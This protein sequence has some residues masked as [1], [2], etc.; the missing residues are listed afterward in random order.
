MILETILKIIPVVVFLLPGYLLIRIRRFIKEYLDEDNF[1]LTIQS[2]FF[3]FLVFANFFVLL[4][5]SIG[6]IKT[7]QIF[8]D[9]IASTETNIG[10][11]ILSSNQDIYFLM[12]VYF[13]AFLTL[14]VATFIWYW[15][16]I[17]FKT[18]FNLIGFTSKTSRL[19]PWD[20]LLQ[21]SINKYVNVTIKTGEK[22]L[23]KIAFIS[24]LP[25]EKELIIGKQAGH[26]IQIHDSD[27]NK[28]KIEGDLEFVYLTDKEITNIQIINTGIL[29][30]ENNS[31]LLRNDLSFRRVKLLICNRI[32]KNKISV[33]IIL[34]LASIYV[35]CNF[36]E[37]LN[38]TN[39]NYSKKTNLEAI[40]WT[41]L[42]FFITY[43]I[44]KISKSS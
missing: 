40:S 44:F 27:F 29:P 11:L 13:L 23:G 42:Y 18:I 21:L 35:I 14:S 24:H 28:I 9:L 26:P 5:I 30:T 36:I 7:K 32:E 25:Y 15:Q 19:T 22:I 3:S 43:N 8:F 39:N 33:I 38:T 2:L 10:K 20:E 4:I 41:Y 31:H 16:D 34:Y 1:N 6:S 12:T 17:G 37:F